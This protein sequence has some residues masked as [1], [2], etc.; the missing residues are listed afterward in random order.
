M[1]DI[2]G[3]LGASVSAGCWCR[4]TVPAANS[5]RIPPPKIR[6]P[7]QGAELEPPPQ[8]DEGESQ[9]WAQRA[10]CMARKGV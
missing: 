1:T 7:V 5:S 6:P 2:L 3:D 4:I 10:G 8:S 9:P